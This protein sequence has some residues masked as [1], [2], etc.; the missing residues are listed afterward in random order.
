MVMFGRFHYSMSR[1]DTPGPPLKGTLIEKMKDRTPT[2]RLHG[3][4]LNSSSLS[5]V[6]IGGDTPESDLLAKIFNGGTTTKQEP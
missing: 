5:R 3:T 1:S 4:L 2:A 6:T